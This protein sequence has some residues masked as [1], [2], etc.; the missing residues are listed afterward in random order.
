MSMTK[1]KNM[2]PEQLEEYKEKDRERGRIYREK[3]KEKTA[4][5]GKKYRETHKEQINAYYEKNKVKHL[6]KYRERNAEYA[7]V[8][9]EVNKN[10]LSKKAKEYRRTH[11]EEYKAR[12]KKSHEKRSKKEKVYRIENRDKINARGKQ[13]RI[14]NLEQVNAKQR[15]FYE[16]R[17][18]RLLGRKPISENKECSSWLGVHVAE[19]VLS[20]VFKDVEQM[21]TNNSGYDFICNKG[22]KI[23]VKSACVSIDKRRYTNR[24]SWAFSIK[25]NKEADFFLLLAFDNRDDLNPLHMWLIPSNV[26]NHKIGLQISETKIKK[27]DEY[28]IDISSVVDCCNN[29]KQK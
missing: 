11:L 20:K 1:P 16:R 22:K 28:K 13:Y 25:K 29:L 24:R 23:D 2:T 19:R 3:N 6:E 18:R 17:G 12:E 27:F 8:Y 26:V 14:E 5:R 9:N 7:K 15:E 10:E 21:P 4:E